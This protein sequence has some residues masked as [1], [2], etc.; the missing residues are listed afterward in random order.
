MPSDLHSTQYPEDAYLFEIDDDPDPL[1][2]PGLPWTF[3]E[4]AKRAQA[5]KWDRLYK[6]FHPRPVIGED[7]VGPRCLVDGPRLAYGWA[8]SWRDL[9]KYAEYHK[10]KMPL[11][12]YL[13]EKLGKTY[14]RYGALSETDAQDDE[15]LYYLDK[16]A[17][18]AVRKHLE[19]E[20]GVKLLHVLPFSKIHDV[21]FALYTNIEADERMDEIDAD[22]GLNDAMDAIDYAIEDAGI[23]SELL[24]WYDRAGLRGVG[25]NYPC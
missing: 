25:L 23:Q 20:A 15:L 1:V 5:A 19:H 6:L 3:T 2:E 18:L 7:E 9:I 17:S 13:T 24:W 10:I 12:E 4:R 21:L 8:F 14:V 22:V 11:Q 16:C